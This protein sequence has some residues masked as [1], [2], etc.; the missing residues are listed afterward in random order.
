MR[1]RFPSVLDMIVRGTQARQETCL[2]HSLVPLRTRREA[3][4][5]S[6]QA[7]C[8]PARLLARLSQKG[9]ASPMKL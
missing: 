7:P 3:T 8:T 9:L 5:G 1:Q 2:L 4:P 6:E